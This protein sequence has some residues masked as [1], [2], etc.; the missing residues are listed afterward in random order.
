MPR[1]Y[2][3]FFLLAAAL[4]SGGCVREDL[5]DCRPAP[6]VMGERLMVRAIDLVSGSDLTQSG[7]VNDLSLLFFDDSQTLVA[8]V[9]MPADSLG[10]EID[11]PSAALTRASKGSTLH[12]SAWGNIGGETIVQ[13]E[14]LQGAAMGSEFLNL[15]AHDVHSEFWWRSPGDM[16]FGLST[17]ALGEGG[18]TRADGTRVHEVRISQKNARVAVTARGLPAGAS[19]DDFFF[20]LCEQNDCYSFDGT[21]MMVGHMTKI[22][23]EGAFMPNGDFVS[24]TPFF[25]IPSIDPTDVGGCVSGVCVYQTR[26]A[27][28]NA[29]E[30]QTRRTRA[31]GDTKGDIDG[32]GNVNFSGK[33]TED[34]DGNHLA[35]YAGQTTNV[36]FEFASDGQVE[37][38]VAITAWNEVY[39]WSTI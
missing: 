3:L 1:L 23:E 38:H 29:V 11:I 21:P 19:A 12:I 13:N 15:N 8:R 10:R 31:E 22:R 5:S 18:E 16:F 36:L 34:V 2:A 9:D 6:F 30:G 4:L 26:Q 32:E 39:Q 27:A 37:I 17:I 14:H 20:S 7:A 25:I 33:A 24:L 35:F 28:A